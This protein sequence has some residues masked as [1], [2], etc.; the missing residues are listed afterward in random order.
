MQY[1]ASWITQGAEDEQL[2]SLGRMLCSIGAGAVLCLPVNLLEAQTAPGQVTANSPAKPIPSEPACKVQGPIANWDAAAQ[3]IAGV[4]SAGYAEAFTPEGKSAW[5]DYSKTAAADWRR[6]KL[7]YVDRI[8]AWRTSNLPKSPTPETVF[9]PFSGPDAT[10]AMAFFP[11][12]RDYVLVGLEPVGCIPSQPGDFAPEYWPALR[13]G[14]QSAV[15]IGFFKTEDMERDLAEGSAGGVLPVLLFLIARA[16]NTIV[17]VSPIGITPGGALVTPSDS[18][19]IETRGVAIQFR[20]ATAQGN[21]PGSGPGSGN[22]KNGPAGNAQIRTL[23]YFAL[24]LI[25]TRLKKKP[26]TMKYLQGLPAG[27]TLV[28][29]ASYLMHKRYFSDIRGVILAKSNVIV[30]DDSGIPFHYFD[31]ATWDVRLFGAYD[32]PI[33]LFKNWMQDDLKAAYDAKQNVQP[34]DFGISYKFRIGESNLLLAVRKGK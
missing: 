13:Q 3:L 5:A 29:S 25:N 22:V 16:G 18:I 31:P 30:Q 23:H 11:D 32:K 17:D 10:N 20:S 26:G 33:E 9:Y 19:K 14:W 8:N 7:R 1:A 24:N 12:A 34:L 27:A 4:S 21:G 6:L 15:A 28:K 2:K